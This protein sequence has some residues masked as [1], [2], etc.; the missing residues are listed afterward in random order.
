MHIVSV[1]IPVRD[2]GRYL[3]EALRSVLA[4]D[5]RPIEVIVVDDGSTDD[6]AEVARSFPEVIYL[7]Q[8]HRGASVARNAGI[9]RSRGSFVAFQD[10]DNVWVP[11]KLTLQMGWLLEHPETG[12]V[13]AFYKNFLEPGVGRPAWITEEQL[14]K[15]QK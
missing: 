11:N 14:A 8:S 7:S 5:Y 9:A 13:A 10:A 6:S 2:M 3:G 1:V 15:E 12:Y 4:Q